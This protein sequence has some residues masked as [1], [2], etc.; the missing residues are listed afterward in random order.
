ML[1][2]NEQIKFEKEKINFNVITW[3]DKFREIDNP[4]KHE[5]LFYCLSNIIFE[6]NRHCKIIKEEIRN[7]R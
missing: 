6:T 7:E 2:N 4:S 3:K 5:C 1:F